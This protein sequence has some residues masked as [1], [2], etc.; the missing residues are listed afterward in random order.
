MFIEKGEFLGVFASVLFPVLFIVLVCSVVLAP[1]FLISYKRACVSA[2]IYNTQ[3][4][5][6]YTCR[7]FFWAED[8]INSQT[9]TIKL[10]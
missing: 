3:H 7:D 6:T 9:Q 4:K 1:C 10:E 8:Q 5:T 2:E